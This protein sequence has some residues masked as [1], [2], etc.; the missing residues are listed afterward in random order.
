MTVPAVV[1]S[2]LTEV[3]LELPDLPKYTK[4]ATI[5]AGANLNPGAVLGRIAGAISAPAAIGTNTGNGTFAATPTA[6]AGI[7]EGDYKLVIIEPAANAGA[8]I[9]EA[10]DGSIVGRGAV[11]AAFT[12]GHLAFTLQD[13]A[14]DFVAGDAFRITV[15]KGTQ[16]VLS[17][18]AAADG[19]HKPVAILAT[20][21]NAAAAA[22]EA[23]IYVLGCFNSGALSYGAG[24]S[25]ATVAGPLEDVGIY[26]RDSIAA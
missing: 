22:K 15:A 19:S 24:H 23:S 18:T 3:V 4:T 25:L 6:A 1:T 7:M 16:Y 12:G 5:A 20:P 9:L 26:L 10:P 17:A 14:T 21:A 2:T 8:F 11:G 13:G